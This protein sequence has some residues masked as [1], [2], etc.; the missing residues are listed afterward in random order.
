MGD[1]IHLRL[2]F[3]NTGSEPIS[4]A[5]VE[6]LGGQ[7]VGS[8]PGVSIYNGTDWGNQQTVQLTPATIG[9]GKTGI[10]DFWIYVTD[11]DPQFRS[12]LVGETWLQVRSGSGQWTIHITISFPGDLWACPPPRNNRSLPRKPTAYFHLHPAWIAQ[13]QGLAGLDVRQQAP[14][15][16]PLHL[17]DL[18]AVIVDLNNAPPADVLA[19][20]RARPELEIVGVNAT[21]SA[22]TVFSGRV[23][24]AHTLTDVVR[25]L[26]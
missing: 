2:P 20:L 26:E 16:G 12:S 22:V 25:C 17:G 18:D 13:L 19:I 10:A 6:L 15:A 7:Q 1:H 5:T 4:N 8:S 3:K 24:L 9:P 21:N 14:H 11:N 23:Y